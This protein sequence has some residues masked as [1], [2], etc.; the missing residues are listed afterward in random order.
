M[1]VCVTVCLRAC[2]VGCRGHLYQALDKLLNTFKKSPV[3]SR[4]RAGGAGPAGGAA[5]QLGYQPPAAHLPAMDTGVQVR[6]GCRLGWA[7]G[8]A[9]WTGTHAAW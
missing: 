6:L 9:G 8:W 2:V 3:D 7:L 4:R 5:Q 1:C